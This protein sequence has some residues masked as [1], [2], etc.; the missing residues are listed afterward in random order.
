MLPQDLEDW[1]TEEG[2][3]VVRKLVAGKEALTPAEQL[4]HELWLFDTEQRNGGVSQYFC[5]HGLAQW[6]TLCRL[7]W[8]LI[9]DF[10]VFAQAVNSVVA[11]STDPY[12]AV[13]N[14]RTYLDDHYDAHAAGIIAS[15]RELASR[16]SHK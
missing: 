15:V 5:N 8:P 6:E 13:I 14:S 10:A 11:G 9:A 4:I 1:L 7:A 3:R 2:D 12:E 16:T